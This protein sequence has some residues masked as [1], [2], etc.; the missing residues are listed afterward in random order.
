MN[1]EKVEVVWQMQSPRNLKDVQQLV[2]R[3][4]ALSYFIS[5][6]VE[7]SLPFFRVLKKA[8]S[9]QLDEKCGG[10]FQELKEYLRNLLMLARPRAGTE[11]WIYLTASE[12]IVSIM[13]IRQENNKKQPIYYISFWFKGSELQYT[14]LEKL[15]LGLTLTSR[16]LC[17]YFLLHPIVVLTSMPLVCILSR[18][19]A[20]GRLIKWA[21]ELNE[22]DINYQPC[23][24]IKAQGLTDFLV[25]TIKT[26][27]RGY[28]RCLWMVL[29][30]RKVVKWVYFYYHHE[31]KKLSYPCGFNFD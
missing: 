28:G 12:F 11:L 18:L 27:D 17:L 15:T 13:L 29:L 24:A 5:R 4:T 26:E 30:I 31:G 22:Y 9:F 10:A 21:T 3:L 7:K 1:L 20:T 2:G 14:A 19:E 8:Y 16:R 6:L 23:M 25:E